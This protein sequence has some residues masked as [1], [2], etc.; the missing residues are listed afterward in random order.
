MTLF[1]SPGAHSRM[2]S[3]IVP[4][5]PAR[6]KYNPQKHKRK[7]G[8]IQDGLR[9]NPCGQRTTFAYPTR[10]AGRPLGEKRGK[11]KVSC[12]GQPRLRK[13]RHVF[14]TNGVIGEFLWG[15]CV[16]SVFTTRAL[17]RH[18]FYRLFQAIRVNPQDVVLYHLYPGSSL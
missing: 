13:R 5:A 12:E 9:G 11:P 10:A 14:L 6:N 7:D 18:R 4:F 2:L 16:E 8:I 3:L 17:S 15:K 1:L